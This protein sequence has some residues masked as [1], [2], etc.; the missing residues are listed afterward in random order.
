MIEPPE[1]DFAR[2]MVSLILG[3]DT[4][5]RTLLPHELE[6]FEREG[7]VAKESLRADFFLDIIFQSLYTFNNC[8]NTPLHAP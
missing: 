4:V 1:R 7:W 3:I 5:Y 8:N 6:G 2:R